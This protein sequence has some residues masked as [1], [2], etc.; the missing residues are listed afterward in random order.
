MSNLSYGIFHSTNNNNTSCLL[1]GDFLHNK[2]HITNLSEV[3]TTPTSQIQKL[4]T[5][6]CLTSS[7]PKL[8]FESIFN[9]LKVSCT[10]S[11]INRKTYNWVK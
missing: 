5:G 2:F 8:N 7:F 11:E 10:Y 6:S 1:S 3:S 4:Q 9:F